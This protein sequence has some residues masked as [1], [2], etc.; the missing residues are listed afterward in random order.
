MDRRK[1]V[2]PTRQVVVAAIALLILGTLGAIKAGV[3]GASFVYDL[4]VP[5]PALARYAPSVQDAH[6]PRLARRVFLVIIDGLRLDRSYELD[7]L[8]DLRR[9]GID[10]EAMSHYPTMSRP[11]YV[12]IL[13]GVPPNASGVRTNYHPAPVVLDSLMDRARAAHITVACATDYAVLPRIF[14]RRVS[15]MRSAPD[16]TPIDVDTDAEVDA[17]TLE[18][19]Q[20]LTAV[21]APGADVASPFDDARYAPWP[22][23]FAEAGAA[24]TAGD[25]ELVVMLVGA[26]DAAGH[27]HGGGS[28]EYRIAA[29]S[30]DHA[31]SRALAGI[32]LSQDTVIITADHG[33]TRR[34]GHGGIEPEVVHVP[35]IMAGAGIR[36][37]AM[38][39]DAQLFDVSP[40]VAALLGMPA[41]GHGLGRTLTEA[42][43]LDDEAVGQIAAA[44]AR[45]V[46]ATRTIV[47]TSEA[48]ADRE[49]LESRASR[50]ALVVSG[51][52]LAVALAIAL[53]RRRVVK[54]DLRLLLVTVPAFFIVYY[55]LIGTLGQ[56]FSP[57]LAPAQGDIAAN[58]I[59]YGIA[60]IVV[61]L[62]AN[63]WALRRQ[64]TLAD[65]LAAAN[66]IA[67]S[68]L[69]LAMAP[70]G[71][72][73][74][75][76]PPPYFT[77]P[78]PSWLV[79]IPAVQVAVSCAAITFA[80]TLG[81]EVIV[82]AA[83]AWQRQETAAAQTTMAPSETQAETQA[84][85]PAET[86]AEPP[87][88]AELASRTS[89]NRPE[90]LWRGTKT[91]R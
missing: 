3:A 49:E 23:G 7:F 83:R 91:S 47:A 59:R 9:R 55:L 43:Q 39:N 38:I 63:L 14:L 88:R 46:S 6:T 65:R 44:D 34:G 48:R 45:R 76:F 24:L 81:V 20:A 35:L 31:L 58:L 75:Y 4:E 67:W 61:Q 72:M 56:R 5:N 84:E 29:V 1:A 33:H 89:T 32:D 41:P 80:L 71:F 37:G 30:A 62:L 68:G 66:G 36:R 8:D 27:A 53:R 51:I 22:G 69:L 87:S 70:A 18:H 17:D 54:F 25:A 40:T 73:W 86:P 21:R 82:F 16:K 15:A 13:T 90:P 52:L 12:A 42:L 77:L 11:N 60:A 28:P 2:A 85:T 50:I 64:Q 78:G 57:S 10:S 74:A 79:L 26:V 19:P